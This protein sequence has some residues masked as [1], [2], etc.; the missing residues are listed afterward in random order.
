MDA[1]VTYD[2]FQLPFWGMD[3]VLEQFFGGMAI[4]AFLFSAV[5]ILF[6]GH[7]WRKAA[8]IGAAVAPIGAGLSFV[9]LL[10]HLSHAQ[11]IFYIFTSFNPGSPIMWGAWLQLI[12]GVIS[13]FYLLS[14]VKKSALT[15]T[16][17]IALLGIFPAFGVGVYHGFVLMVLRSHPLWNTGAVVVM[18]LTGF[19][20]SGVSIVVL[21]LAVTKNL[22]EL[23]DLKLVRVFLG[24][25]AFV[26]LLSIFLW[27]SS[28]YFGPGES[29]AALMVFLEEYS[30]A[31]WGGLVFLGL[32][33]PIILGELAVLRESYSSRVS[34]KIP[35][36]C[37]L[38]LLLGAFLIRFLILAAEQ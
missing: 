8:Y 25:A 9:F 37:S 6:S 30:L 29:R 28:L 12:F 16:R 38:L 21:Y 19:L 13:V 32:F 18:S 33:C 17:N 24:G 3:V 7:K 35:A 36:L 14:F 2:V 10:S 34:G 31:F 23:Q 5:L 15:R 22:S 20:L 4:G 11:R 27:A 26:Q 1:K